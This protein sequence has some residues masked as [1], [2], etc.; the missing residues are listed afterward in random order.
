MYYT[1]NDHINSVLY[2]AK[3]WQ[4]ITTIGIYNLSTTVWVTVIS[5]SFFQWLFNNIQQYQ[6]KLSVKWMISHL[7]EV[8]SLSTKLLSLFN[9][10]SHIHVINFYWVRRSVWCSMTAIEDSV[11]FIL[12]D[13]VAK[14][15]LNMTSFFNMVYIFNYVC[16]MLMQMCLNDVRQMCLL[17]L[18]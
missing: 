3:N 8:Y 4:N 18:P 11:W 17:I 12:S 1:E 16:K 13:T 2:F 10:L 6:N 9:S 7:K 15:K 14:C 5:Y